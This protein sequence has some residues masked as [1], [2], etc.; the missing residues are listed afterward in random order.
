[1]AKG[2][3]SIL[4]D[5]KQK[6]LESTVISLQSRVRR[7]LVQRQMSREKSAALEIQTA[8]RSSF[9]SD[10]PMEDTPKAISPTAAEDKSVPDFA[11]QILD[12]SKL[13]DV[14]SD[15]SVTTWSEGASV[16]TKQIYPP[17]D[18]SGNTFNSS[19]KIIQLVLVVVAVLM[20][21]LV[22]NPPSCSPVSEGL[23]VE[24]TFESSWWTSGNAVKS[25]ATSVCR[26]RHVRLFVLKKSKKL[27]LEAISDDGE[28]L[29]RVKGDAVEL[30]PDGLIVS[31]GRKTET[32]SVPW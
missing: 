32:I 29:L 2:Q 20:G 31:R 17:L 12:P 22:S 30:T 3:L 8:M 1:M 23:I 13:E 9:F 10:E 6:Q 11:N 21:I 24:G 27:H 26:S 16:A 14:P 18:K 15:E 28:T 7:K 5:E 25:L 19:L 4:R